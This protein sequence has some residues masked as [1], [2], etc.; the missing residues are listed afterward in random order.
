MEAIAPTA[1]DFWDARYE[2]EGYAYGTEPNA[3]FRQQL[4]ALPPGRLLLL[5]E[6]EGRNA[7][8]AAKRGWQVTA[9]DFS[10]E[11]RAKA[12]RLAAAQGV[13]LTYQ[14]ADLT[15]LAWQRPG[16]YDAVGLIYAHL[17]PPHRQAV[18]AAAAASLVPGGHLILEAF[19]PR[20]LGLSSGGPRIAEMLYEPADL[21]ADFADL[22]LLENKALGVVLHEGSF[23]DG[24]ANVVRLRAT[25]NANTEPDYSI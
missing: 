20:Q 16:Y 22:T 8:Y 25:R 3:Y 4:D 17:V 1:V 9:V 15:D 14:V 21:A 19:S 24:P 18:H 11:G 2:D 13:R 10:D 6:G 7:V 23:L 12:H 5:A